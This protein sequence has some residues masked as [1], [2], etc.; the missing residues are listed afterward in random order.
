MDWAKLTITKH[1]MLILSFCVQEL[2]LINLSVCLRRCESYLPSWCG[3]LSRWVRF[4]DSQSA[5]WSAKPSFAGFQ[6]H[7]LLLLSLKSA[8]LVEM[9]KGEK[10]ECG[11]QGKDREMWCR[12]FGSSSSSP[13]NKSSLSHVKGW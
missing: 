8:V 4:L 13:S 5:C 3:L 6:F 12:S 7:F 10:C 2:C 11:S 9:N 1:N